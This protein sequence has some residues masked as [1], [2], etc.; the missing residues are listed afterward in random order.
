[1]VAITRSKSSTVRLLH[2]R[3]CAGTGVVKRSVQTP[4]TC[5]DRAGR[6]CSGDRVCEVDGERGGLAAICGDFIR[7]ILQQCLAPAG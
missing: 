3:M 7:D 1:L 5:H 4:E 2:R 6:G